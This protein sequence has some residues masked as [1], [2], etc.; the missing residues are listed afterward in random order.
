MSSP[1]P[2]KKGGGAVAPPR[3]C[4]QFVLSSLV[5]L[6]VKVRHVVHAIILHFLVNTAVIENNAVCR[7]VAAPAEGN[8]VAE[9]VG[10]SLAPVLD[11][12]Y[13]DSLVAVAQGAAPTVPAIDFLP[14]LVA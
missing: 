9:I 6:R 11:V 13:L 5:Q 4:L 12:V 3:L 14:G 8:E 1:W 2:T 10:A 7:S